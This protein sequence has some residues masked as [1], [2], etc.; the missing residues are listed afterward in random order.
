MLPYP[1]NRVYKDLAKLAYT[2]L[3]VDEIVFT[4]NDIE[5]V[6][7]NLTVNSSNWNGLGLLKAVR[8]FD[9]KEGCDQVTF[10]FLHFSVQEYM[11]ALY[12][13]TY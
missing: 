4:I 13:S 11:A 5:K 1:H 7:P 8:C 6:C 12:F 2:A 9:L 3:I 10:H